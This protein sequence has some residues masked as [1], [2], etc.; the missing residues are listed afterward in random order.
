[1]GDSFFFTQKSYGKGDL[2]NNDETLSTMDELSVCPALEASKNESTTGDEARQEQ[3]HPDIQATENIIISDVPG[4][5]APKITTSVESLPSVLKKGVV[6][7]DYMS[8][9]EH[10]NQLTTPDLRYDLFGE[11]GFG[12]DGIYRSF[13]ST[14]SDTYKQLGVQGETLQASLLIILAMVSAML[15]F[16]FVLILVDATSTAQCLLALAKHFVPRAAVFEGTEL[17]ISILYGGAD[18]I[19]GRTIVVPLYTGLGKVKKDLEHLIEQGYAVRQGKVTSGYR[20]GIEEA[21]V[22][23]P[24]GLITITDDPMNIDWTGSNVIKHSL[25]ADEGLY[26]SITRAIFTGTFHM[27]PTS[28]QSSWSG[29]RRTE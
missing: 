10:N 7:G 25:S 27:K 4:T 22:R 24:A 26:T 13:L 28:L 21:A 15:G 16:P 23:G 18:R 1:L 19:P 11:L 20:K 9:V 29:C 12:T 2:M 5:A 3:D 8:L 17:S 6:K 14:I